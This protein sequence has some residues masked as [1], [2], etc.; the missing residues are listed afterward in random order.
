MNQELASDFLFRKYI[1]VSKH[2]MLK[3]DRVKSP[4]ELQVLERRLSERTGIVV[5][6]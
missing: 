5:L 3:R 1:N 4:G 2:R 6:L